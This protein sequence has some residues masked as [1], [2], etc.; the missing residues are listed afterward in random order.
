[1][2]LARDGVRSFVAVDW[3]DLAGAGGSDRMVS[4]AADAELIALRVTH[5]A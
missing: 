5:A 3:F 4:I 2:C 1:M